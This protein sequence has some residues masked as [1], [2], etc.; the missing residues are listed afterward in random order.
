MDIGVTI[1]MFTCIRIYILQIIAN[2]R[3]CEG[4]M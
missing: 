1:M 3:K 4:H 2:K